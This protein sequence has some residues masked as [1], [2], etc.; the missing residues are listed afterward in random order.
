[1]INS[2]LKKYIEDNILPLYKRNDL[3]HNLEHI[4][5]VID[6]S[7]KFAREISND[8]SYDMIYAIAAYHDIGYCVDPQNHEKVSA[9]LL[10]SD[11]RLKQFFNRHEIKIM[12][13]AICDHRAS[14]KSEPKNIYGRILSSADRNTS[15]KVMLKRI[16]AYEVK[17]SPNKSLD[18]II[19]DARQHVINKFG[20]NG[21]AVRK[22]YFND[23]SYKKFLCSVELLV[24]D[25]NKFREKF[26]EVNNI[27][28]GQSLNIKYYNFL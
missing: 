3:G 14:L 2:I 19:E 21:Y 26:I 27:A 25:A 1:M 23:F 28:S 15:V 17:N 13:D 24:T 18:K 16:Y 9:Y 4:K 12:V 22:M 8:I 10:S 5:Y 11:K 20:K 6:R 7:L